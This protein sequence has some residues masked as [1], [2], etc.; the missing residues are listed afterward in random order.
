MF[1]RIFVDGEEKV[2]KVREGFQKYCKSLG[3]RTGQ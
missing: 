3:M 1:I 2:G